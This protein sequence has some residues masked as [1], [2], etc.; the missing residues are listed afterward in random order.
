[1]H[2]IKQQ[3]LKQ[4]LVPL[5]QQIPSD[6]QPLWG[7]MNLQQMVEH[8]AAAVK[9]ASGQ[10]TLPGN[11]DRSIWE[12]SKAFLMTEKPFRENTQNPFLPEEPFPIRQHTLAASINMLQSALI[13]F[14]AIYS[15]DPAKR[16]MNLIFGELDFAAQVQLLH[17]HALHHLRQFGVEPPAY[18][19]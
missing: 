1:M 10:L 7:K 15:Q 4:E 19:D 8:L 14:F 11:P 6:T 9:V 12:R 17:K 3:F 16:V 13:E 2:E 5:L 18:T